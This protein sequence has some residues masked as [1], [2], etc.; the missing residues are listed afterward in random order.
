M[1][2]VRLLLVGLVGMFAL[3]AC[4]DTPD[5]VE[6]AVSSLPDTEDVTDAAADVQT[7][8]NELGD[9]IESSDAAEDL[10]AAW[11]EMRTEITA[12]ISSATAGESIDTTAIETQL[13]QFQSELETMGDDVGDDVMSAWNELRSA[14]E[15]LMS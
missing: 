2:T 13:D 8:L 15:Q 9:A 7:E 6:D 5:S 14:F 11:T 12:A 1:R 3:A 4:S 10:Q